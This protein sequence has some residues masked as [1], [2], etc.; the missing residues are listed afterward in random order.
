MV[1][2]E[3]GEECAKQI[4]ACAHVRCSALTQTGLKEVFDRAIQ[5]AALPTC[6]KKKGGFF[7]S[8][9]KSKVNNNIPPRP[10]A[11]NLPPT[12][13]A[14]WI[15]IA[16]SRFGEDLKKLL[17]QDEPEESFD[18]MFYF[19]EI[20]EKKVF[21]H[22]FVLCGSC[23]L[24]RIIFNVGV[25]QD[26]LLL[27]N[28]PCS[29]LKHIPLDDVPSK[30]SVFSR[31]I[32]RELDDREIWVFQMSDVT[33]DVWEEFMHFCYTGELKHAQ[34]TEYCSK[35]KTIADTFS[36]PSLRTY[37]ENI[38][39]GMHELNPS[40]GTWLLDRNAELM[41]KMFFG[42][43][44][45]S[46]V[47][48]KVEDVCIPA[49]EI[50]LRSRCSVLDAMLGSQFQE[51]KSRELVFKETDA[52]TFRIFLEF[53]YTAHPAPIEEKNLLSLFL[54]ADRLQ[55]RRL[56]SW[57]GYLFSKVVERACETNIE[58]SEFDVVGLLD[59][60]DNCN[61]EQLKAFCLHFIASNYGP[62]S[63]RKEFERLQGANLKFIEDHQWP[64]E[65]FHEKVRQHEKD[66][67]Q[68]EKKH[69]ENSNCLI[70]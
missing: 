17:N 27:D 12:E 1:T 28:S 35:L 65:D 36:F 69:G 11:P 43:K 23:M 48:V 25:D 51:A 47:T 41:K 46:D 50:L 19:K 58:K 3:A 70:M 64:G 20:E 57:S 66:V 40:I 44:T 54:L 59:L 29:L 53:L 37:C 56:V 49:H 52:D 45:L 34:S 31:V 63:K 15:N 32:Y 61:E 55:V 13:H 9:S 26:F 62:M 21:A 33:Y 10:V 8:S 42:K 68:W 4:G 7:S 24:F 39:Q 67:A 38:Q 2:E 5:H 14:P 16:P 18:V 22:K 60:A 30:V 6:K